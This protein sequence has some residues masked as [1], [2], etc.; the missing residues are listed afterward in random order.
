MPTFLTANLRDSTNRNS[1]YFRR[2]TPRRLYFYKTSS[3]GS[4]AA[5]YKSRHRLLSSLQI[6]HVEYHI[7]Q[8]AYNASVLPTTYNPDTVCYLP[9]RSA[10]SEISSTARLQ[11]QRA[12]HYIQSQHCLLHS[13]QICYV[14]NYVNSAPIRPAHSPSS[15]LSNLP[16]PCGSYEPLIMAPYCYILLIN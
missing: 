2:T 9:C 12:P 13:L 8:R 1:T 7:Q 3:H 11:C 15:T 4:T 10:K 6:C 14:G 5:L 16:A